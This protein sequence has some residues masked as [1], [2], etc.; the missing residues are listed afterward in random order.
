LKEAKTLLEIGGWRGELPIYAVILGYF[1]AKRSGQPDQARAV[2]DEAKAHCDASAWVY[3][4]VRYLRGE[5]DEQH[6]LAAATDKDKASDIRCFLGLDSLDKGKKEA[7]IAHFRWVKQ[8][9]ND[10]TIAFAISRA[11]LDRLETN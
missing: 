11:E 7:A 8:H 6:A 10:Q 5:I 3:A 9:D 4:M 2:L 1:A